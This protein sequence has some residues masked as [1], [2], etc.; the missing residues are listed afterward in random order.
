MRAIQPDGTEESRAA[1]NVRRRPPGRRSSRSTT[2]ELQQLKAAHD[3]QQLEK[4]KQKEREFQAAQA[5]LKARLEA[6]LA[7][8]KKALEVRAAAESAARAAENSSAAS[9]EAAKAQ[10]EALHAQQLAMEAETRKA[11]EAQLERMRLD[12]AAAASAEDRGDLGFRRSNSLCASACTSS[13]RGGSTP[14]TPYARSR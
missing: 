6:E 7:E 8:A 12:Q 11:L 14:R 1:K 2:P 4:E 10:L 5:A 13:W 9:A 3:A